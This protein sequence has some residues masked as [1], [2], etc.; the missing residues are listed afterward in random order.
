MKHFAPFIAMI[1]TLI[2]IAVA[3]VTITNYYLKRRIID[4]GPIDENA[5]QFLNKLSGLGSEVLKWGIILL[6]GGIGLVV[7]AF[8]PYSADDS[9]LP[10]GIELIFV[11]IGFLSYYFIVK[12]GKR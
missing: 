3:I 9:P 2:T 1:A 5:L 7:L 6:F 8:V 4:K 10:Y 12:K 11:A